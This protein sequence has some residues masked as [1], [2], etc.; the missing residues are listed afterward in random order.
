MNE[1]LVA[2]I[3]YSVPKGTFPNPFEPH[4][5][6]LLRGEIN[7]YFVSL[8]KGPKTM[9]LAQGLPH[10]HQEQTLPGVISYKLNHF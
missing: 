5:S 8:L 10:S 6:H 7:A 1:I 9:H 2:R 3:S 4:L